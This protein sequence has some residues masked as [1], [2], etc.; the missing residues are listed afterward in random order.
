M[1]YL[2]EKTSQAD[3]QKK[4]GP[5]GPVGRLQTSRSVVLQSG[6]A[7]FDGGVR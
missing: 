3:A 4:T 6:N 7:L 1:G 2:P 5:K